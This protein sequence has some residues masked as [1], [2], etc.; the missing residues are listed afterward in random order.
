MYS[1]SVL[2][3]E[4]TLKG[5]FPLASGL[6]G[7]LWSVIFNTSWHHGKPVNMIILFKWCLGIILTYFDIKGWTA[8]DNCSRLWENKLIMLLQFKTIL[9]NKDWH[10]AAI[11]DHPRMTKK[12]HSRRKAKCHKNDTNPSIDPNTWLR[13]T[14]WM[15]FNRFHLKRTTMTT[16][17][18]K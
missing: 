13:I 18:R 12:S 6:Y 9:A 7:V 4:G 16:C 5:I 17:Y 14:T 10:F 2:P 3:V 11:T 8:V 15:S 1:L